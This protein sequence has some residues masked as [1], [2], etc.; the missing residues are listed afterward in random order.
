MN[1]YQEFLNRRDCI[2]LLVDIQKVMLDLCVDPDRT[3]FNAAAL[4][5]IAGLFEI[6]V[7]C[8][9]QNSVRLGGFLPE[10]TN[11]ISQPKI[12]DKLQFNCFESEDIALT[13]GE[14]GRKTLLLAG[15]EGHVCIFH[16]GVGA[17]RLGYRVHIAH[18]AV[19]SRSASD[20]Q[21][22]MQR[23]DRAGAVISSTEM[24]I[25]ELLNRAGTREFR[26]ALPLIKKFQSS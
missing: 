5:E 14:T 16:T 9:V 6:P 19:T 25:F 8:S 23:L 21:I 26:E 17:L 12:W 11:K 13:I 24:I 20:K 2:L 22:G 15:L 10:L 1:V 3:V 4:I 7:L 18:D